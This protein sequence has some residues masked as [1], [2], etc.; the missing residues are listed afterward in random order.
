VRRARGVKPLLA[1]DAGYRRAMSTILDANVTTF[2]AAMVLF[3]LGAGPIK[4]F[5]VT[6]S[7]GIATSVFSAVF[8]TRLIIVIWMRSGRPKKLAGLEGAKS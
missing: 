1:I 3:V 4:G 8:L 7:I 5:A 6:L 2:I